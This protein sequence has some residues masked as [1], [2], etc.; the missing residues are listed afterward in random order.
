MLK[1]QNANNKEYKKI[2]KAKRNTIF[3]KLYFW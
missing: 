3:E 1:K 2:Y